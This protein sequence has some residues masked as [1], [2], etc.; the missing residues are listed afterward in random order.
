[1]TEKDLNSYE[2]RAQQISE[3]LKRHDN[4]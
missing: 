3:L 4:G 2:V 1:M